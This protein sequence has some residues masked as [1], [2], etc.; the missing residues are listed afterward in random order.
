MNNL[1]KQKGV[2]LVEVLVAL[3][4]LA[5][6]VLGYA[7]LQLRAIDATSE[8]LNRSQATVILRGLTESIRA[9]PLAQNS[10]PAAV[11]GYLDIDDEAN[12]PA[13]FETMCSV[14]E[15]AQ[16]DAYWAARSAHNLGMKITMT[17]CPGVGTSVRRQ[18]LFAAW[19]DTA[20]E[21][22]ATDYSVCMGMDG[23]YA[24]SAKCLMMEAY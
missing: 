15:I 1:N 10:Y 13:C 7:A 22:G 24:P 4:L 20:S 3:V 18:C 17:T 2:G 9:N 21:L 23:I 8:A 6:G 14:S 19:D 11:Q 16:Y 5:V 12:A